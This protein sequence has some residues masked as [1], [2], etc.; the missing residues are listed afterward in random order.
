MST[1]E[2]DDLL[3]GDWDPFNQ[4]KEESRNVPIGKHIGIVAKCE[5]ATTAKGDRMLK[6]AVDVDRVWVWGMIMLTHA[7]SEQAERLGRQRFAELC[8]ACGFRRPPPPSEFCGREIEITVVADEWNGEVRSKI[9]SYA[10]S[11][12]APPRTEITTAAP[13]PSR[14]NPWGV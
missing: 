3:G 7:T 13:A 12:M 1:K 2:W 8:R 4:P 10:P 11:P 9:K 14:S 6:I 5:L